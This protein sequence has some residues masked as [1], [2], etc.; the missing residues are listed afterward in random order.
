VQLEEKESAPMSISL[1]DLQYKC[2]HL[3]RWLN[4]ILTTP[5]EGV[6]YSIVQ[7]NGAPI[8]DLLN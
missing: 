2:E 6:P 3:T 1:S 7:E 8:F 4:T 5:I